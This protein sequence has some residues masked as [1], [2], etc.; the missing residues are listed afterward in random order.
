MHT[1]HPSSLIL[2]VGATGFLGMEICKQL[3]AAKQQVRA[4]V[5]STSIQ[6]KVIMLDQLGTEIIMGDI[7]DEGSIKRA[8]KGVSIVISCAT[9]TLT[10][11]YGD[12]IETVDR[13]GQI[14]LVNAAKEAGIKQFIYISLNETPIAS[15]LQSAKRAVEYSLI[16]SNIKYTVLQPSFFME[17]WLSPRCGFDYINANATIYGEGK[18]KL[19]WISLKDVAA[20]AVASI[21]N[22]LA[23][24]QIFEVG[25]PDVLAPLE[26]V[27]I[28]EKQGGTTFKVK[29]VP[30]E[31]LDNCANDDFSKSFS[32]AVKAYANGN[33]IRMKKLAKIF[34]IKLTS[35][36]EYAKQVLSV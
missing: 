2:V 20:L 17:V 16:K 30:L 4:L 35:V 33:N 11:Q 31:G 27:S 9:S 29:H 3:I 19:A 26:V 7:K 14:S 5:R 1:A 15:P 12:T 8:L 23:E 25:G 6:D 36:N 10:R 21:D 34:P 18:N 32:S 13:K 22:K 24:N 28:F